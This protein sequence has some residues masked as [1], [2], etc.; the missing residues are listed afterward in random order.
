MLLLMTPLSETVTGPEVAVEGTVTVM[1]A[2][3][4]K[5]TVALTPLNITELLPWLGP[6][7]EPARDIVAPACPTGGVRL[8]ITGLITRKP[9]FVLLCTEFTTTVTGPV[10]APMGTAVTI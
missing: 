3:L 10:V 4:Q 8:A 7:P 2:S 5:E 6:K 9:K 1:L